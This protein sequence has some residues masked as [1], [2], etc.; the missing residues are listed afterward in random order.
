MDYSNLKFLKSVMQ[1]EIDCGSINGS[2]IKIIHNNNVIYEDELGYA[3]KEQG[4]PIKKDTIYRM[5]SMSKPVTTVA[6]MI[7]YERGQLDLLAPVQDYLEGFKNQKVY[8]PNGLEDVKRPVTIQDLLNMTSGVVYPDMSY[9]VG[10]MM[11]ELYADVANRCRAG[12][13]VNT[14]DLCNMIGKQPLEFHPGEKWRYGASADILGAVIEVVTGKK[15]GQFLRD[16]IFTPL[17]MVDTDFYVPAKKLDRFAQIYEYIEKNHRLEPCT[18]S[19]L[20]LGNFMDYPAF[21]SGGAGLVSTIEDYSR[22]AG[23]LMNG[24]TYKDVRILG[25]KTIDYITKPQ[26]NKSQEVDYN[27]DSQVGYSY[28]NL[29]RILVDPA[30]AGSNGSIGEFGWD[31]W[32]G[33]YFFV[34]PKENLILIYMIQKCGGGNPNLIR[35]FRS[36]LY[37]SL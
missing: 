20:G 29:M 27:W 14:V 30:K 3:D 9:K 2:A 8:T 26:L 13:P 12:K 1:K 37:G 25:K 23:M 6:T 21:E 24:G 10:Q 36:I 17:G 28:G 5:Y 18:W 19:F 32:T 11:E 34:D 16:E 7:L 22:F 31:G 4:I 35:A 15:F 33:N